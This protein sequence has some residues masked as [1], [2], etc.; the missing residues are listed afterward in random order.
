MGGDAAF[1]IRRK[2]E[3]GKSRRR[4]RAGEPFMRRLGF[5]RRSR[6][7]RRTWRKLQTGFLRRI[8]FQFRSLFLFFSFKRT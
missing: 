4:T 2:R 5:F 1:L 8:S 7:G 6:S 3:E